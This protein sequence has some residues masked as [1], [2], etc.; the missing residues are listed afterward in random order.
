MTTPPRSER[1][2]DLLREITELTAGRPRARRHERSAPMP[3]V[4]PQ[5]PEAPEAPITETREEL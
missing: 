5:E 1:E 3:Q 2:R 4:Q